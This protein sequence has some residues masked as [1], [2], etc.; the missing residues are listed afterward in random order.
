[1]WSKKKTFYLFIKFFQENERVKL[2]KLHEIYN[3]E[4]KEKTENKIQL[5]STTRNWNFNFE[6]RKYKHHRWGNTRTYTRIHNILLQ[7]LTHTR[8][9]TELVHNIA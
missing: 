6:I 9:Y 2:E 8:I 3:I 4:K 1:M 5:K 7:I